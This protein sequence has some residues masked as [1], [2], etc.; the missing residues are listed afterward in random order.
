MAKTTIELKDNESLPSE[1]E[2]REF[3]VRF[4]EIILAYT[5]ED[6]S[7]NTVMQGE[8]GEILK[9]EKCII[10]KTLSAFRIN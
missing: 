9:L 3:A 4:P 7:I 1:E 8:Y 2:I 5:C 6:S 10:N